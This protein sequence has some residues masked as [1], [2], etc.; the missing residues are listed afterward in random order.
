MYEIE[1]LFSL[2][3]PFFFREP[4]EIRIFD[5][6]GS[7]L[8]GDQQHIYYDSKLLAPVFYFPV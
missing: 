4:T 5:E 3:Y 7:T 6:K 8:Q 1:R 2:V